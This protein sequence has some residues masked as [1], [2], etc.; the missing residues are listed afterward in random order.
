MLL[1]MLLPIALAGDSVVAAGTA[2]ASSGVAGFGEAFV[3][4]IGVILGT[5]LGDKTFFIAAI[6]SMRHSPFI[7][8]LGAVGALATMTVLGTIVG[9]VAPMLL[10]PTVT[11]YAAVCLFFVFGAPAWSKCRLGNDQL[12]SSASSWR[13]WRLRT[14]RDAQ[15]ERPGHWV[16]SH[17]LRVLEQAASKAA[18]PTAFDHSGARMLNESREEL[19][20]E[21]TELEEVEA[22]LSQK[23][24]D[25]HMSDEEA[26]RVTA[27]TEDSARHKIL[28]QVFYLTFLAEWGDRSQIATIALAAAKEPFGVTLGAIVGHAICTCIAVVG[29][30]LLASRISAWS[31]CPSWQRPSSAPVPPQGAPGSGRLDTLSRRAQVTGCPATAS[32]A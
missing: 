3:A 17:C 31:T 10:S 26:P 32:G 15:G 19:L 7:V 16:L 25:A 27:A 30:K 28:L 29:G 24:E 6:M 13:A 22:E 11:H 5:E 21:G 4:S 12:G 20:V 8:W 14:A 1:V 18:D 2:A 9:H 23:Q